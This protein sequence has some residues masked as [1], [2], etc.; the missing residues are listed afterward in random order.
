MCKERG[1]RKAREGKEAK[2]W[3]RRNTVR[4]IKEEKGVEEE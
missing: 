3:K 1:G 4:E 2:G